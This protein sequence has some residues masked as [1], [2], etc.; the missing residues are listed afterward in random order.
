VICTIGQLLLKALNIWADIFASFL[1]RT[2][3]SP[4][5]AGAGVLELT[6]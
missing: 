2:K 4:A 1:V 5:F 3:P 6:A